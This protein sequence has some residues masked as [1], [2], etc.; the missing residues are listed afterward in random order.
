MLQPKDVHEGT[1]HFLNTAQEV[2]V[3]IMHSLLTII[4]YMLVITMLSCFIGVLCILQRQKAILREMG[5][6]SSAR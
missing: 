6:I 3:L 1:S 2:L 5:D 4:N